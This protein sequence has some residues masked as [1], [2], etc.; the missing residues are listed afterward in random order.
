MWIVDGR[1]EQNCTQWIPDGH[2]CKWEQ[3]KK[4]A[5]CLLMDNQHWH[6]NFIHSQI[7]RSS[8]I[9]RP[10]VTGSQSTT[11]PFV[12]AVARSTVWAC[13]KKAI[14]G[15]RQNYAYM[16]PKSRRIKWKKGDQVDKDKSAR[17][18]ILASS[19]HPQQEQLAVFSILA[20]FAD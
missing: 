15:N 14:A 13:L 4:A 18:G 16:P 6:K 19:S 8:S 11:R 20:C 12:T 9:Y 2:V 17:Y 7:L 1:T 10:G 5:Y 3:N